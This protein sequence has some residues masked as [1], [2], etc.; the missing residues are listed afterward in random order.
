MLFTWGA[1]NKQRTIV[2][3]GYAGVVHIIYEL[4][5]KYGLDLTLPIQKE[6]NIYSI[7][8]GALIICLEESITNENINEIA[9]Q[10]IKITNKSSVSRVIFKDSS[11][12]NKDS[13]KT[14]VKEI[15][16]INNIDEFITI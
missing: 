16:S 10:I 1:V 4:I 11:F 9:N 7:G 14:N 8:Y 3:D 5:L 6:N 13:V 12:N 15:L 2:N